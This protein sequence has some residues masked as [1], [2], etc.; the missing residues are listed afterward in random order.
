MSP[1]EQQAAASRLSRIVPLK[2]A[3][4][5]LILYCTAAEL[6]G[7]YTFCH[8]QSVFQLIIYASRPNCYLFLFK[9]AYESSQPSACFLLIQATK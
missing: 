7:K 6:Q 4:R 1:R 2:L 3:K 8:S 9:G 5:R